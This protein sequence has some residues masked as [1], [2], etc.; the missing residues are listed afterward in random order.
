MIGEAARFAPGGGHHVDVIV[1]IVIARVGDLGS[2]RG[3]DRT[4][5]DSGA[6]HQSLSVAARAIDNPDVAAKG[7]SDL[8]LAERGALQQQRPGIRRERQDGREKHGKACQQ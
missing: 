1:P 8:G 2:I 7:E 5:Q 6:G 3:K 4:A